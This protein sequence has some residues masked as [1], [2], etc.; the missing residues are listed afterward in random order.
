MSIAIPAT[1]ATFV[2]Q[3]GMLDGW[4][5]ELLAADA[6]EVAQIETDDGYLVRVPSPEMDLG[7]PPVDLLQMMNEARR[8][9]KNWMLVECSDKPQH[10]W[11]HQ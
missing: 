9:G 11:M 10:F 5:M 3:E 6:A 8:L 4:I 2:V 7:N 1:S